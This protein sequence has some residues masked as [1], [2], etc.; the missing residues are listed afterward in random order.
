MNV[1]QQLAVVTDRNLRPDDTIW[2]D[3]DVLADLRA[4]I[5]ACSWI[6]AAHCDVSPRPSWRS[7]SP[8]RRAHLRL[9][10][11]RGTTTCCDAAYATSCDIRPCRRA[12]RVYGI[13]PHRSS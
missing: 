2:T 3:R 1:R 7:A 11:R 12:P 13:S 9:W 5:D 8:L 6:D 10:L 4:L